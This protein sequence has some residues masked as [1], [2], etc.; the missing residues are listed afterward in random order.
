M[1][2]QTP[3]ILITPSDLLQFVKVR[4]VIGWS[5]IEHWRVHMY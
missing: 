3:D 4:F 1:I 5:S 2:S